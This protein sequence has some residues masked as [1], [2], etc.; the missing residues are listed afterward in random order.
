MSND[1]LL[2]LLMELTEDLED[3]GMESCDGGIGVSE[4]L[5]KFLVVSDRFLHSVVLLDGGI[6]Q[7]VK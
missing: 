2:Y 1:C 5:C 4:G 6:G 7:V 3:L